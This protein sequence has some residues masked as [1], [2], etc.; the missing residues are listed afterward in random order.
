MG[1]TL[2][3]VEAAVH[4]EATRSPPDTRTDTL[5]ECELPHPD[6]PAA[7]AAAAADADAAAAFVVI[8]G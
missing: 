8:I 7:D 6:G 4:R 2:D 1:A 3:K 5:L